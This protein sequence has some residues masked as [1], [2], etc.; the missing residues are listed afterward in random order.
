LHSQGQSVGT[1]ASSL[2]TTT[3]VIN[4]DLGITLEKELEQAIQETVS[5]GNKNELD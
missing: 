1:I 5:M 3:K 2:G 4:S